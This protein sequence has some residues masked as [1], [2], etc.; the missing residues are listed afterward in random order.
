M[1]H[2]L[3]TV[4]PRLVETDARGLVAAVNA[5]VRQHALVVLLTALEPSALRE[6]LLPFL[7]GLASRHTVVLASVRDDRLDEL[8]A[9]RGDARAVYDA[10]SAAQAVA[11]R[12]RMTEQLM[13]IG[14]DVVD[15]GPDASPHSSPTDI[16]PSRPPVA[17][18]T[19]FA[20][21]PVSPARVGCRP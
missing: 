2:A 15:A 1:S 19:E 16:S 9:S 17:S 5:R 11:S 7:A 4:E 14:V 20:R 21:R 3:S 8:A 6:G 18:D 12:D 13:R 10:A